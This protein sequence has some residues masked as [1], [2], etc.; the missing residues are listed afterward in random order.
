MH[1]PA[2]QIFR[3]LINTYESAGVKTVAAV[4]NLRYGLYNS[5]SCF[6][7]ADELASRGVQ[8]VGKFTIGLNES[9]DRVEEII[10]ILKNLNPDF[11]LWCDWAACSVKGNYQ[12]FFP[13]QIFKNMNY[14]PPAL[15]MLDCENIPGQENNTDLKG[16]LRFVTGPNYVNDKV[17]GFD[18]V[19]DDTAFSSMFRPVT[20]VPFTGQDKLLLGIITVYIY[21]I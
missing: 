18:F 9:T 8:L 7:A 19:E 3:Q 12:E 6:N 11:V 20:P 4:A 14:L 15:S 10:N 5:H 1:G 16:L 21:V 2:V 13:L 17:K